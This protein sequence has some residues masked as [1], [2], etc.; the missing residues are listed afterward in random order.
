MYSEVDGRLHSAVDGKHRSEVDR[1][2]H[3]ETDRQPAPAVSDNK[4]VSTT[5]RIAPA[6]TD[7]ELWLKFL[8]F[9]KEVTTAGT[10][11]I[12]AMSSTPAAAISAKTVSVPIT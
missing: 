11:D 6:N 2:Q 9:Q 8:K 1:K 3:A 4:I 12:P 10:A 5:S 7:Q